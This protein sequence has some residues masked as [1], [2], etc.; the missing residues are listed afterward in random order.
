[1]KHKSEKYF[2]YQYMTL[3][4]CIL[5][6]V[7]AVWQQIQ[8]LYLLA[9]YSLS[10][11][12]IFDGLGHHIRNEQADFYQQLIRALLIFLLTTLFYF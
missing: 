1:M 11:S 8:L 5:L 6:A 4:A 3:L 2:Q 9:F 7:V 10:L 12:F